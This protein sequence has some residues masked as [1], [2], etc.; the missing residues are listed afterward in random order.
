ML[1]RLLYLAIAL[2]CAAAA[3]PTAI[4]IGQTQTDLGDGTWQWTVFLQGPLEKI[5]NVTCVEYHFPPTVGLKGYD[6][7][8]IGDPNKPFALKNQRSNGGFELRIE[9]RYQDQTEEHLR[10]LVIFNK[11]GDASSGLKLENISE[12]RGEKLWGWT[13]FVNG[14]AN[15]LAKIR[16][17]EYTLHPSFPEPHQQVCKTADPS[18]PFALTAQGWGV[19]DLKASVVFHDGSVEQLD[20]MLDFSGR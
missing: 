2:F 4:S 16:C 10:H 20:H 1:V 7:C 14:P 5:R 6:Q 17:V 18:H 9:I 19:F 11:T 8:D 13:A 15:V 3:T 12:K